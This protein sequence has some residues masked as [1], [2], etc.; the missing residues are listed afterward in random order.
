MSTSPTNTYNR[1]VPRTLD[2]RQNSSS[3]QIVSP[4]YDSFLPMDN[5]LNQVDPHDLSHE[6]I[7]HYTRKNLSIIN[8]QPKDYYRVRKE[9][10]WW[11][12]ENL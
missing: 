10:K 4:D 12:L 1:L 7:D 9:F 3:R 6:T 8:I 5:F 11:P 2:L